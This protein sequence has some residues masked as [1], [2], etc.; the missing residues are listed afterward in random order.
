MAALKKPDKCNT[1]GSIVLNHEFDPE[2]W[3]CE[4]KHVVLSRKELSVSGICR[5]CGKLKDDVP[6]SNHAN[7]CKKCK[8]EYHKAYRKENYDALREQHRQSYQDNKKVR[9]EAVKKA[10][11]R[12]PEA[13]IRH[14]MHH[15][16]KQSNYRKVVL[17]KKHPA[18]LDVNIDY[19]YLME[20]W[21]KQNGRCV[22]TNLPM[23][24][25]WNSMLSISID[26]VDSSKGYVKGNVQLVCQA[27][28]RLKNN[29]ANEDV[30]AFLE[31]CF[32]EHL[33]SMSEEQIMNS[34][35]SARARSECEAFGK[36]VRVVMAAD[37]VFCVV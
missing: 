21:A 5:I 27:I 33:G 15:I 1:C 22:I 12:S 31:S 7:I 20:L 29:N 24:H 18:S 4:N 11:Q 26:R 25:H 34:W 13:F 2:R 3:V 8:S 32:I 6:F 14:L 30:E 9:Q 17:H 19:E 16:T 35:K 36:S 10:V 37:T 23:V 28:N